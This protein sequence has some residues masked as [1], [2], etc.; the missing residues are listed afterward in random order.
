MPSFVAFAVRS[1][2]RALRTARRLRLHGPNGGRPRPHRGGRR[3]PRRLAQRFY[4]RQRALACTRSSPIISTRSTPAPSTRSRSARDRPACRPVRAY[5][6]RGDERASVPDDLAPDELTVEKAAGLLAAPSGDR[7]LGLHPSGSAR[8]WSERAL[9]PVRHR[10]CPRADGEA[11]AASLFQAMSPETVTLSEA[12][13]L[14]SLPRVLEAPDGEEILVS[15][16]RYG[17]FVKK[18][19]ETRSLESEEQLFDHRGGA[20]G[21]RQ[22]EAAPRRGAPEAAAA[23]ARPRSDQRQAVVLKEAVSAHV[24]DGE[25]NASRGAATIRSR[26][27]APPS[28]SPSGARRPARSGSGP[29]PAPREVAAQPCEGANLRPESSLSTRAHSDALAPLT[30]KPNAPR[31]NT[32][33]SPAFRRL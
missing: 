18:G 8:S 1:C 25:T 12:L 28:C 17:P 32:R 16:G 5:V 2:S 10:C 21:A 31:R 7:S 23:R 9:R 3:G 14:L 15:N 20:R 26:S 33:N 29:A 30:R 24:T 19:S 6:E 22:A 4:F 13:R 27:S 11:R